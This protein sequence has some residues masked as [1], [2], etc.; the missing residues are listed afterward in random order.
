MYKGFYGLRRKR[1]LHGRIRRVRRG[2]VAKI[3]QR[4][5]KISFRSV[6]KPTSVGEIIAC[7]S[8]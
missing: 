6:V 5:P 4:G 1:Y 3:I 2:V 7:P 8:P